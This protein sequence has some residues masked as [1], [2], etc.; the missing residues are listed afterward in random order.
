[1]HLDLVQRHQIWL[2]SKS[3]GWDYLERVDFEENHLIS[4][5]G[6]GSRGG[7]GGNADELEMATLPNKGGTFREYWAKRWMKSNHLKNWIEKIDKEND[8]IG[9]NFWRE[10]RKPT[11]QAVGWSSLMAIVWLLGCLGLDCSRTFWQVAKLAL[12]AKTAVASPGALLVK[13]KTQNEEKTPP[14]LKLPCGT[15]TCAAA[16][17]WSEPGQFFSWKI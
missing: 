9:H 8:V 17:T 11:W 10:M 1:M 2:K 15:G 12:G 4:Q 5:E 14:A 16:C 6:Q 3:G 7:V 13:K